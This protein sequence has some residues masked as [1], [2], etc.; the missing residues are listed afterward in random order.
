M[1]IREVPGWQS[2]YMAPATSA[3]AGTGLVY[4][5]PACNCLR[6]I[7]FAGP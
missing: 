6:G 7:V 5:T 1:M 3:F 4:G 2:G